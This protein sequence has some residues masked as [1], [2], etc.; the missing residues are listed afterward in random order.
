MNLKHK[1]MSY[2]L[3]VEKIILNYFACNPTK[4][5]LSFSR[6]ST[7]SCLVVQKCNNSIL[8]TIDRDSILY[9]I[10][11]HENRDQY[12]KVE[13]A[14]VTLEKE[15]DLLKYI[16]ILNQAMPVY[17]SEALKFVCKEIVSQK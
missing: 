12:F 16:D 14:L 15:Y 17:V 8:T 9:A 4:R 2:I 1:I 7:I 10:Y 3:N 11:G 5:E 13:G 6:I